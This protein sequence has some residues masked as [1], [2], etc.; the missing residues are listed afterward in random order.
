MIKNLLEKL[1]GICS[2]HHFP[3]NTYRNTHTVLLLD[4]N[5]DIVS[6]GFDVPRT[7]KTQEY[8]SEILGCTVRLPLK[9][10]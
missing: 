1:Q 4:E 7:V 10:T 9:F 5:S 2:S 3:G 8:I 6:E